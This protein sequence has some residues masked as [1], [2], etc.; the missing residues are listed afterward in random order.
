MCGSTGFLA[1][2]GEI[3][4]VGLTYSPVPF[5]PHSLDIALVSV[6]W[7][8]IIDNFL[9]SNS[10]MTGNKMKDQSSQSRAL[11]GLPPKFVTAMRTLFDVLDDNKSGTV[12]LAD[13]EHWWRKDRDEHGGGTVPNG[14]IES[15]RSVF[16]I[17]QRSF[18]DHHCLQE[19]CYRGQ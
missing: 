6:N 1:Q 12:S 7:T 11:E 14:V 3:L 5:I 18:I 16:F 15:L 13:I 10:V 17:L 8:S 4:G 9:V 19:G 2:G